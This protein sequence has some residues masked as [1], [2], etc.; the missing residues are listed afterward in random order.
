MLDLPAKTKTM[1]VKLQLTQIIPIPV[2]TSGMEARL[3]HIFRT[4]KRFTL[5]LLS[6]GLYP[7]RLKASG[8]LVPE[9]F[10]AFARVRSLFFLNKSMKKANLFLNLVSYFFIRKRKDPEDDF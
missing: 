7:G 1:K 3:F 6:P 10:D 9:A 4:P 8:F 2:K 5:N